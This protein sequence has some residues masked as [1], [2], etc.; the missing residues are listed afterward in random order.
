MGQ[1]GGNRMRRLMG[2]DT[3]REVANHLLPWVKETQLGES[4]FNFLPVQINTQV[5]RNKDKHQNSTFPS[6]FPKLS[7]TASPRLLTPAAGS[8]GA[9]GGCIVVTEQFLSA[10]PSLSHF[11]PAE[12]W[13]FPMG[14]HPSGK[15]PLQRA[16]AMGHNSFRKHPLLPCELH[17]QQDGGCPLAC[18]EHLLLLLFL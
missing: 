5:V 12:V 17:G 15:E 1:G 3:D 6:P 13:A 11:F 14:C 2:R 10:A 8:A 9:G 4:E 7:F 16:L 18:L